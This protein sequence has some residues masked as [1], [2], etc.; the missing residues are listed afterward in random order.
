MMVQL[1]LQKP[2]EHLGSQQGLSLGS[3]VVRRSIHSI[4]KQDLLIRENTAANKF[5]IHDHGQSLWHLQSWGYSLSLLC[6]S[7]ISASS[8]HSWDWRKYLL[9]YLQF[10]LELS[11]SSLFVPFLLESFLHMCPIMLLSTNQFLHNALGELGLGLIPAPYLLCPHPQGIAYS[12]RKWHKI[13]TPEKS[14]AGGLDAEGNGGRFRKN[15]CAM[16]H[17]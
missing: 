15:T 10:S 3:Q 14:W 2:L 9:K 17:F 4:P 7:Q 16:V 11:Q 13:Q 5:Q 1:M 6:L 12:P 8:L